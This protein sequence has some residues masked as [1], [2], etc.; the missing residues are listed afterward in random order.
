LVTNGSSGDLSFIP[1]G[2]GGQLGTEVR[3]RAGLSPAGTIQLPDGLTRTSPDEPVGV[4]TGVFDSSGLTDVV[5]ALRGAGRISI[6]KGPPDGGLADPT[7]QTSYLTGLEPTQVVAAPLGRNGRL[8][9][10]VLN[11]GSHDISI[12]L[13]DGK[14][15]FITMPRVDGGDSPTGLAVR[16]VN[17]DGI[18]DL[19]VGNDKGD[20]LLLI[21]KGDGTFQPYVRAD[22]QVHLAVGDLAGNG[23]TDFVTT[24][25][26]PDLLSVQS[27]QTSI[28]F[29]QGRG[30][31]L[32]APGPVAIAD[33]NGNGNPDLVVANTGGNDVFVYQGLGAA[34]SRRPRSST[35]GPLP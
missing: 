5:V 20:L 24:N 34:G 35:P 15:G 9:L 21:G 33:M 32:Q 3:L 8:D 13:N 26:S 30:N 19:L 6:L 4:T 10:A 29:L 11:E 28:S 31:G 16:D 25:N 23:T 7:F 14:G 12:F 18:A 1:G 17:G 2:P 27:T 22:R